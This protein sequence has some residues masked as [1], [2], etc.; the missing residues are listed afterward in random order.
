MERGVKVSINPDAHEKKGFHD[1]HFGT[2]VARKGLLTKEFCFNALS[3]NEME[4][5]LKS[6]K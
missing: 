2:C 3:L 6:K 5:Y 1:M 4:G